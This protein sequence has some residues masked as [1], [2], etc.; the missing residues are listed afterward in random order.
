MDDQAPKS[1]KQSFSSNKQLMYVGAGIVAILII[2]ALG[3]FMMS[4][5][6][7][8][9]INTTTATDSQSEQT[10]AIEGKSVKELMSYSGSQQCK[11]EDTSTGSSGTVYVGGGKMRG[12]FTS[13]AATATVN[14]HMISDGQFAYRWSDGQNTGVKMAIG[15]IEKPSASPQTQTADVDKKYDYKCSSWVVD[16]SKFAVPAS[17]KFSD[18]SEMMKGTMMQGSGK[19]TGVDSSACNSIT[20]ATAKAACLK[21]IGQ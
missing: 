2:A 9:P 4:N 3:F 15:D 1:N 13:M 10:P 18:M 17:V 16:N 19:P 20:D 12:D 6:T 11:Y 21:A 14:S 7:S 5:K 8:A